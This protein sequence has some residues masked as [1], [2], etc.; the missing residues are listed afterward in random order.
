MV[1]IISYWISVVS[2]IIGGVAIVGAL[3]WLLLLVVR[4]S[5]DVF[6]Q[7]YHG[8]KHIYIFVRHKQEIM[9]WIERRKKEMEKNGHGTSNV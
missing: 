4:L 7:V 3:T 9:A 1:E 5:F 8:S 2:I 6:L